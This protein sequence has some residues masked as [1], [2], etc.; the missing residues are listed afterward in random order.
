MKNA[1]IKNA[2]LSFSKI[3]FFSLSILMGNACSSDDPQP[4]DNQQEE[5]QPEEPDVPEWPTKVY[6]VRPEKAGT[7]SG[8][9]WDNAMGT[10]ELRGLLSSSVTATADDIANLTFHVAQGTYLIGD[11]PEG[12]KI[13]YNGVE[14]Q[15]AIQFRGGYDPASTGIDLG[16]RDMANPSVF[17]GDV[18]GDGEANT[19]DYSLFTLGAYVDVS[20]DGFTFSQGF[21]DNNSDNSYG[22]GFYLTHAESTLQLNHCCIRKCR[23]HR[24]ATEGAGGTAIFADHGIVRMNDVLLRENATGD[25]GSQGTIRS[26]G[27]DVAVFINGSR[28]NFNT[29]RETGYAIQM[30]GGNLCINNTFFVANWGTE[31]SINGAAAMLLVN[32]TMVEGIPAVILRCESSPSQQSFLMNNIIVTGNA[33]DYPL[34]NVGDPGKHRLTSKGYNLLGGIDPKNGGFVSSGTDLFGCTEHDHNGIR[35]GLEYNGEKDIMTWKKDISAL[36]FT[37]TTLSAV[38]S[39]IGEFDPDSRPAKIGQAL[40]KEFLD[41]LE[42]IAAFPAEGTLIPGAYQE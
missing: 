17:T 21:H 3:A 39:A 38:K 28:I 1:M 12:V 6:F 2:L 32:N 18:N 26:K 33:V 8:E 11:K 40:G 29:G 34:V 25:G 37:P 30:A 41:W 9:N 4:E 19:G 23:N 31:A 22:S 24:T 27:N 16:K 20:F 13:E 15:V 36:S 35:L 42:S 14:K 5:P 10:A 7:G